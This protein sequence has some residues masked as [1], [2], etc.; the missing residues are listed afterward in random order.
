MVRQRQHRLTHRLEHPR[1][2]LDVALGMFAL[3]EVGFRGVLALS[4]GREKC[5]QGLRF[6][7]AG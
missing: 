5:V 1:Q 4:P 6:A 2:S 3:S 7:I